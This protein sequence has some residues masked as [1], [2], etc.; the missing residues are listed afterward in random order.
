[1]VAA[2][3]QVNLGFCLLPSFTCRGFSPFGGTHLAKSSC[4]TRIN[5]LKD[6]DVYF[7]VQDGEEEYDTEGALSQ[8]KEWVHQLEGLAR[9]SSTDPN[10]ITQAQSIFDEMFEAYVKTD[11][12]TF[13]PTVDVYNHLI[14]AHAYSRAE[15]GGD[16]ADLILSRMEDDSNDFVAR[17]DLNTYL[18]V[19]D[20]WAMRKDAEKVETIAKRLE[21]RFTKTGDEALN[22]SVEVQNKL[23]KAYGIVG[24][25]EK[26]ESIFRETLEKDGE[27]K[28]NY[29]T[30]IQ[31]M[32]AYTSQRG[33]V[34]SVQR[35]FQE[36][37]KAYR[38]GEEEYLPRTEAYNVLIRALGQKKDGGEEA[39]AMLFEMIEQYQDGDED[40]RPNAETFRHT[41]AAQAS[42]KKVAGV[43]V[44]QLLQIQDGLYS[45]TK[46]S[47]L[48]PNALLNNAALGVIARSND[49]KKATRAKRLVEKMK[50]SEDQ[51][52]MVSRKAYYLLLSACAFTR[53]TPEEK[54]EAFQIL[55]DTLKELRNYL[56]IEPD[57]SCIGMFL[58]GC[59]NLMPPSRKRDA[60]VESVF[61]KC[62]AD[63]LLNEFVLNEFERA[64]SEALQ[65]EILGGFLDDDV[66]LPEEWSRN[67]S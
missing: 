51:D 9:R 38:M 35:L 65:L 46:E 19:M 20:A 16:E 60:V 10:A 62:C 13:F 50:E 15:S 53:G 33:E 23:I 34:E 41:I 36:M 2:T 49:S 12:S 32:K 42:R 17:P 47:D 25:I 28:A 57:S 21:T 6:E 43:K 4:T 27:Q 7:E 64:A 63:G 26:S 14:E 30:W 24:D 29:K 5:V 52:N 55:V 40:M 58:K 44:E 67:A 3:T 1:M 66:R 54:F 59:A 31:I 11:D 56:D 61:T 18:N 45:S 22:P 37:L 39:E 8:K 48:K